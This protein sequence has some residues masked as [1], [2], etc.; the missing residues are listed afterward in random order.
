MR[1][2]PGSWGWTCVARSAGSE[3]GVPFCAYLTLN[4]TASAGSFVKW[5]SYSPFQPQRE[6]ARESNTIHCVPDAVAG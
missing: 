5:G 1:D 3:S 2:V 6:R 4:V